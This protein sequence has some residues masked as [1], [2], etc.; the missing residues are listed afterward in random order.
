M[1]F[2][3][4]EV[5]SRAPFLYFTDHDE[6][7]AAIV[8]EGRRREFGALHE[9]DGELP[10]PNALSSFENSNPFHD[11]PDRD[12]WRDFYRHLLTLR[13]M[14]IV[15][16]LDGTEAVDA[17]AVT[18]RAVLARWKLGNGRILTIACNLGDTQVDAP[19]PPA[20]PLWG[21]A[22]GDALPARTTL[23]WIEAP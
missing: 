14:H 3:G 12:A 5:G 19:L 11:A 9:V 16:H 22:Q 7:L 23:A 6:K 15:P 8:R 1:I 4:E 20:L 10:D 21:T 2:M 18:E 17:T 13:R